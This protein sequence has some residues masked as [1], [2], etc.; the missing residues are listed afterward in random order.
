ME[1]HGEALEGNTLSF[2][3]SVIRDGMKLLFV[4]KL[5]SVVLVDGQS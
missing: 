1:S 5:E 3:T 2:L 4:K